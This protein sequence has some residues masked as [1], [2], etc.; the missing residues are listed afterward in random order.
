[1][2]RA[3]LSLGLFALIGSWRAPSQ[4][5]TNVIL[6]ARRGG[7]IEF[8]DPTTLQTLS[9]LHFTLPAQTVGL[10]GVAL[11]A[12][13]ATLYVDG[14]MPANPRSCCV[15]YAVDLKTYQAKVAASIPGSSSRAA[16]INADG[17]VYPEA[18]LIPGNPTL[19]ISDGLL[20]LSPDGHWLFG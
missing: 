1:M 3:F 20:H 9:S 4:A 5:P 13:G 10:N 16:L 8:I 14:P 7:D 11:S 17:I 15:L 2:K 18:Q 6:A 19:R 12:D